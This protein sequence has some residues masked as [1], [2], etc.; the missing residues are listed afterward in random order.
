[1]L[2]LQVST[3]G[4]NMSPKRDQRLRRGTSGCE[5]SWVRAERSDSADSPLLTALPQLAANRTS[6]DLTVAS[7]A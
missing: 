3:T 5:N 7:L 1:V 2:A 4:T 6:G